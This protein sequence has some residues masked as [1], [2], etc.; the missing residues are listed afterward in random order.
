MSYLVS[1][2]VKVTY[3]DFR[4]KIKTYKFE[5]YDSPLL[6]PRISYIVNLI[7]DVKYIMDINITPD[8]SK[9]VREYPFD[10]REVSYTL[11]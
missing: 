4:D 8:V 1:H 6:Y 2:K 9:K 10:E 7:E 11:H 3:T 5:E